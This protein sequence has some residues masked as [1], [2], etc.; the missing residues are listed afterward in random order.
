M[1]RRTTGDE[2]EV[3]EK[4]F[5]GGPGSR[6]PGTRRA[7][8]NLDGGRVCRVLWYRRYLGRDGAFG[9]GPAQGSTWTAGIAICWGSSVGTVRSWVR[10]ARAPKKKLRWTR[11]GGARPARAAGLQRANCHSTAATSWRPGGGGGTAAAVQCLAAPA[12]WRPAEWAGRGPPGV[13]HWTP[14]PSR[15]PSAHS[16]S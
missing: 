14:S 12:R 1:G 11:R 5:G 3:E 6:W 2:V 10:R 15:F 9:G 7:A 13:F 8:R 16:V 4:C